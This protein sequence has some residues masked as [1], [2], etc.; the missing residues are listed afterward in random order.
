MATVNPIVSA[1]A[2]EGDGSIRRASWALTTANNIGNAVK[3]P[4]HGDRTWSF[5]VGTA[6][7][8]VL[9]LQGANAPDSAAPNDGTVPADGD[10][11]ALSNAAGGAALT[12]TLTSAPKCIASI[13]AAEFT[14]PKLTTA[15]TA[16]VVTVTLIARR[17]NPMRT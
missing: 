8:A 4:E 16:T 14:R 9:E 12:F 15:G 5:T 2:G 7:G 6:G 17:G 13:E 3:W 11:A 1:N 10:Y